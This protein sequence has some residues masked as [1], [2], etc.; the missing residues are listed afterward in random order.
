MAFT[1]R[2]H[3]FNPSA[4]GEITS[5]QAWK[6]LWLTCQMILNCLRD[7]DLENEALRLAIVPL[8]D[9]LLR[10]KSFPGRNRT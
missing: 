6:L 4:L 5:P 1:P 7:T 10:V 8:T 9:S 2:A 3:R